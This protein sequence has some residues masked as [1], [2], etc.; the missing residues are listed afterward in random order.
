MLKE[1]TT[2]KEEKRSTLLPDSTPPVECPSLDSLDALINSEMCRLS[3]GERDKA[4]HDVHGVSDDIEESHKFI[5]ERQNL[6][7]DEL[8]KL[9]DKRSAY[10]LAHKMN[11]NYV[12]NPEFRLRFLRADSFDAKQAAIRIA[13]HFESKLELFGE[14]KLPRDIVQDDLE[15]EDL[16]ILTCG[17]HQ[18]LPIR[19]QA[20]RTILLW[21][22]KLLPRRFPLRNKVGLAS[23]G[24]KDS[25][26][27]DADTAISYY[28]SS[29][30]PFV[31][32]NDGGL[33]GH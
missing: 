10:D 29:A 22:P 2:Y 7:D 32:C 3:L 21:I 4:L 20:G 14:S 1:A 8:S 18:L 13:A 25:K 9:R 16:E 30:S 17:V 23:F 27:N 6:L 19:D 28:F 24:K 31:L 33:R 12:E 15:K 11:P 26:M 5:L